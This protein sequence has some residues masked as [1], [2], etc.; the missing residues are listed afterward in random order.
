[1]AAADDVR[2]MI[3]GHSFVKRFDESCFVSN[4]G[5][6][7]VVLNVHGV[8]GRTV[9]KVRRYDMEDVRRFSPQIIVLEIGSNDLCDPNVDVDV[10][11]SSVVEFCD[12][13]LS[14]VASVKFICVCEVI[15]RKWTSGVP[16]QLYNT[17]VAAYN[18]KLKEVMGSKP[19]IKVWRHRGFQ[20]E[21]NLDRHLL[22]DG[23]HPNADG[24]FN[25]Y[26]SYRGAVLF[27]LKQL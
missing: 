1:M 16:L 2:V 11:V 4:L 27:A 17:N 14:S 21:I 13:L 12:F 6:G 22:G 18:I 5:I 9:E 25:L 15:R 23:V 3:L 24:L 10:F 26:L 8:G 19:T 20:N 7:N